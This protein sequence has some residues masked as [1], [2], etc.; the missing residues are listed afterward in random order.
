MVSIGESVFMNG[1]LKGHFIS[2]LAALHSKTGSLWLA[3]VSDEP[4]STGL[5]GIKQNH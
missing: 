3:I 4:M 2:S 1:T 5:P